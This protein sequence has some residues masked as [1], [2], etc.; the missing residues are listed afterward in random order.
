M[1][2]L[3]K[4]MGF[5]QAESPRHLTPFYVRDV[6]V[7]LVNLVIE[8][9]FSPISKVIPAI[10]LLFLAGCAGPGRAPSIGEAFVGPTELKLR[11][12]IPLESSTAAVVRHGDR[13]EILQ[14]RRQLFLRVRAPNGAEGWTES[15]Q[16]LTADEMAGLR[17]LAERARKMPSQGVATAFGELRIHTQPSR[18]APSF[19]LI[20]EGDKVDVVA[21]EVAPRVRTRLQSSTGTGAGSGAGSGSASTRERSVLESSSQSAGRPGG[22]GTGGGGYLGGL[23]GFFVALVFFGAGGT[24]ALRR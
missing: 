2:R 19:L 11:S 17:E 1:N 4:A 14:Q 20:K 15:R 10:A 3:G 18:S 23:E 6:P 9:D 5:T 16:L 24:I 7:R 13:L 12:D 21:H 8:V 22:L